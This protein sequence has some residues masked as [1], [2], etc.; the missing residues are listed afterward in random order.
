MIAA[1]VVLVA[2]LIIVAS[3]VVAGMADDVDGGSE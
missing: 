3:C 1:A 2:M